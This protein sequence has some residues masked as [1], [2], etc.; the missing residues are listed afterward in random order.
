MKQEEINDSIIPKLQSIQGQELKYKQLSEALDIKYK[1]GDSKSHQLDM[2][3]L[4]CDLDILDNPTRYIVKKVYDEVNPMISQI[5]GNNKFQD[6]FECAM[7]QALLNNNNKPLYISNMEMLNMFNEVNENF[8]YLCNQYYMKLLGKEYLALNEMSQIVY[9][10]LR[11]WTK[12]RIKQMEARRVIIRRQGFRLYAKKDNVHI[13]INIDADSEQEQICQEI[14][15]RAA[16]DTMPEDW[17]GEWV[18]AYRWE[19]FEKRIK[20]L[21]YEY[22]DGQYY[23]LK[24]I[25]IISPPREEY[26]KEVLNK[27]YNKIPELKEINQ[28]AQRKIFNTTQLN[29]YTGAEREK[30]I[31]VSIKEKPDILLINEIKN[32]K[33]D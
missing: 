23:D 22:F 6:I 4:Y 14:Y 27:L 3:A 12:R 20:E 16:K 13:I 30:L 24:P 26:L 1:Y 18:P 8:S 21:V 9:K 29:K 10:I 25:N 31:N 15:D 32:K 7:Y 19:N 17:H 33:S 28:E 11:E 5:N 2:I